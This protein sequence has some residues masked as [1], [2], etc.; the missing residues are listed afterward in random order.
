[1]VHL[2][3]SAI[4]TPTWLLMLVPTAILCAIGLVRRT[5]A[6]GHTIA[7][8]MGSLATAVGIDYWDVYVQGRM[9]EKFLRAPQVAFEIGLMGAGV[10]SA[11]SPISFLFGVGIFGRV[12]HVNLVRSTWPLSL[13]F[14][15]A[16]AGGDRV[17]YSLFGKLGVYSPIAWG[18]L[19]GIPLVCGVALIAH[20]SG[21]D[22]ADARGTNPT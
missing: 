16:T 14:G 5:T 11:A 19:V 4:D 2:P 22:L 12:R 1:M 10:L 20:R 15:T 3:I 6:W 17:M 18:W 7:F 8:L 9:D 21:P 13:L